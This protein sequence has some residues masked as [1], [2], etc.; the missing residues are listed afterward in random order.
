MEYE[1]SYLQND[2]EGIIDRQTWESV[3]RILDTRK[4]QATSGMGRSH[5][6]THPLYGKIV[7]AQCGSP[8]T[9]KTYKGYGD[10]GNYHAWICSGKRKGSKCASGSIRE[11]ALLQEIR[12]QMRLKSDEMAIDDILKVEV[13][14]QEVV[15]HRK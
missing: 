15:V 7:C 11:E 4:S 10:K 1:S 13:G 8:F 3:Q 2:H 6:N 9:R 12:E 14:N 5:R